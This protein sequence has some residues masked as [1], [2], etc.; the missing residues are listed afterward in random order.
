MDK[1]MMKGFSGFRV[2]LPA[3]G[4]EP[5]FYNISAIEAGFIVS[6]FIF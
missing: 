2:F 1:E 6:N 4:T 3:I 5:I